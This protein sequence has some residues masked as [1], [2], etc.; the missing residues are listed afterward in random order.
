MSQALG[1]WLKQTPVILPMFTPSPSRKSLVVS[2]KLKKLV[3]FTKLFYLAVLVMAITFIVSTIVVNEQSFK[4][5]IV[6][7]LS[8]TLQGSDECYLTK[9]IIV[10]TTHLRLR[11]LVM[12][13]DSKSSIANDSATYQ[14][15]S[16]FLDDVVVVAAYRTEICRAKRG[17]FKDT[18]PHDLLAPVLRAVVEKTGV[19]AAEVG[20]IVIVLA[21]GAQRADECRMAAFFAWFPET[22]PV[23]TV[24]RQCS[25]GLLAIA[26]VVAA[27][28]AGFYDISNLLPARASG[29]FEDVIIPVHTKAVRSR[30]PAGYRVELIALFASIFLT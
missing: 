17:G 16:D 9:G 6:D 21:P 11:S 5:A 14:R 30:R 23:R 12:E 29:R 18:Y 3:W 25:S 19:N 2:S 1:K 24:N 26:D 4:K 27:I 20:D 13:K 28:K 15:S 7:R 8:R 22:V 10:E